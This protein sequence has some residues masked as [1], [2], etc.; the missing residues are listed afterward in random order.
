MILTRGKCKECADDAEKWLYSKK[1]GLCRYHHQLHKMK[2]KKPVRLK[3]ISDKQAKRLKEYKVV[4]D[5][6]LSFNKTC[7]VNGCKNP[8]TQ[9][10][11][12]AGL[13]GI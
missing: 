6:F 12:K 2:T 10:H 9:I 8:A 3:P 1:S 11:H 13:K 5:E 7:Q 4:R